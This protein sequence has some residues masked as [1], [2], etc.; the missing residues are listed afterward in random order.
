MLILATMK[1]NQIIIIWHSVSFIDNVDSVFI[2]YIAVTNEM[3][4]GLR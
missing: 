2:W 3:R 4:F 1:A